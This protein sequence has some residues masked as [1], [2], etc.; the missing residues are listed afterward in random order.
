MAIKKMWSREVCITVVMV[1]GFFSFMAGLAI[2]HYQQHQNEE[3]LQEL[4]G[5][6]VPMSE[7]E[8]LI[9]Q[10]YVLTEKMKDIF[11]RLGLEGKT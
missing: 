7:V 8:E 11:A 9:E 3:F 10:N 6:G 4:M 1:V 5:P 2:G